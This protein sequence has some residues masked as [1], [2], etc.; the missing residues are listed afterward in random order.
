MK[1]TADS[2]AFLLCTVSSLCSKLKSKSRL[3]LFPPATKQRKKR[4]L[5]N[6]ES[7]VFRCFDTDP[8]VSWSNEA[9]SS[10]DTS[11]YQQEPTALEKNTKRQEGIRRVQFMAHPWSETGVRLEQPG[12]RLRSHGHIPRAE[13]VRVTRNAGRRPGDDRRAWLPAGLLLFIKLTYK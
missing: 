2:S 7:L 3:A 8:N 13:G 1:H 4:S 9:A 12:L 10:I 6:A 5:P 11:P